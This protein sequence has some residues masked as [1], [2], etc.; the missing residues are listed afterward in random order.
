MAPGGG[1]LGE[2]VAEWAPALHGESI[3]P[4]SSPFALLKQV[5]DLLTNLV[6]SLTKQPMLAGVGKHFQD[7]AWDTIS[8]VWFATRSIDIFMNG[9]SIEE[10]V[11]RS[12]R[13]T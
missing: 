5:P 2:R 11:S 9:F 13:P 4:K 7:R 8:R 3:W 6:T 12:G 10:R 1:R